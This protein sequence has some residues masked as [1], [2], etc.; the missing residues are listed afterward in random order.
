MACAIDTRQA[1]YLARVKCTIALVMIKAMGIGKANISVARLNRQNDRSTLIG[2]MGHCVPVAE[3]RW[4]GLGAVG[5]LLQS[6]YLT[7]KWHGEDEFG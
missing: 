5:L 7:S 1:V 2:M 4:T 6:I 3:R